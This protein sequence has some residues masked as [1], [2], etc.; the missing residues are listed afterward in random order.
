MQNSVTLP[1]FCDRVRFGRSKHHQPQVIFVSDDITI[2]SGKAF[3]DELTLAYENHQPIIPIVINSDGGEV[4][5]AF[6]MVD[7]MKA[8][9]PECQLYTIVS[10]A[11]MSAASLI[12]SAG[13]H[14]IILADAV[15][16]IHDVLCEQLEG[17]L[18]TIKIE[19]EEMDRM[20]RLM[21]E[22]LSKNIG[23]PAEFF[24]TF[25]KA[26]VDHYVTPS[27]CLAIGLA[28]RVVDSMP[29][30]ATTVTCNMELVCSD[31]GSESNSRGSIGGG[32]KKRKR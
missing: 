16:M 17:S 21:F 19:H 24:D 1:E 4:Y 29:R 30:L 10:G 5:A 20:N 2:A 25:K 31:T 9:P 12:F 28:T 32:R 11:A 15:V 23:K 27:E 18:A 8:C 26:N 22:K 14:R 3:I 13:L 6:Q 7:V